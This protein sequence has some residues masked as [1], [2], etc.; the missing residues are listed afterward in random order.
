MIQIT[1]AALTPWNRIP[2]GCQKQRPSHEFN[3]HRKPG[4]TSSQKTFREEFV[5]MLNQA[6]IEF[7]GKW[8]DESWHPS[9][10]LCFL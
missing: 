6:G 1:D 8:V 7:E 4:G 2:E 3:I 10:M 5:L 9:G